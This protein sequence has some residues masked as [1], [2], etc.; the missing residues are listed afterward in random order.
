MS[1][2]VAAGCNHEAV[3]ARTFLVLAPPLPTW[4]LETSGFF[5]ISLVIGILVYPLDKPLTSIL[6]VVALLSL[7]AWRVLPSLNKAMGAIVN[8]RA[9][10]PMAVACLTYFNS[11]KLFPQ[12]LSTDPEAGFSINS[13]ISLQNVTF[14]YAGTN[15]NS[16]E[17]ISLDISKFSTLGIV[18]RSGSGKSTLINILS[19]LLAPTEGRFLIDG[20]VIT[21][22]QLSAYRSLVGYVP[23]APFLLPGTVAE[24]V[25]FS[26]WGY[27]YD[28][29]AVKNACK[30]AAV[31]FLG[32]GCENIERVVGENGSGFSGG[33]AQR[34]A[35]AR[36][37][38]PSPSLIIF[39]EATSALDHASESSVHDSLKKLKGKITCVICSHRLS[40][41]EICDFIVWLEDGKIVNKGTPDEII[42]MY[43]EYLSSAFP[44]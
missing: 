33:Q 22:S 24:N 25:A 4:I 7:S 36:A 30:A 38:Y 39:D 34:I 37:L 42:P 28:P 9:H 11:L 13:R 21:P 5:L 20:R 40:A 32:P 19:G 29:E 1:C 16:L 31:D 10:T 44:S 6:P 2:A 43:N 17:K 12:E 26:R 15:R 3:A 35:I 8:M 18:G 14:R 27:P 23:Q 41:L